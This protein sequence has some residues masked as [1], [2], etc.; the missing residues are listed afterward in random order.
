MQSQLWNPLSLKVQLSCRLLRIPRSMPMSLR[1]CTF[2][3]TYSAFLAF[4]ISRIFL[5]CSFVPHFHVSQFHVPHFTHPSQRSYSVSQSQQVYHSAMA[6]WLSGNAWLSINEVTL[7]R[8][9][10]VLGW[11]TVSGV[12]L[13]VRKNYLSI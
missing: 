13:P 10:L 6:V 5:P 4:S 8:T 9:R 7:R 3:C 2:G 1:F 12:K 11:V